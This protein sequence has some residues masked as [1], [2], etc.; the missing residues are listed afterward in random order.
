MDEWNEIGRVKLSR[1]M[2]LID[3]LNWIVCDCVTIL[4]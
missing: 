2:S 4:E 1:E 3:W